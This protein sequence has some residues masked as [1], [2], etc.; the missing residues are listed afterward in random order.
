MSENI[1]LY[2]FQGLAS[3]LVV[4]IHIPFPGVVGTVVTAWARISVPLFFMI[5][6]YSLYNHLGTSNFRKKIIQR[7]KRN[8]AITAFGLIIYF[9]VDVGKCILKKESVW[10]FLGPVLSWENLVK[11]FLLGVIPPGTGGVLWFMIALVY[12]YTLLLFLEPLLKKE[13]ITIWGSVAFICMVLLGLIK[14]TTTALNAHIS[15]FYLG[16]NWIYGNW[17]AI[18]LPAFLIGMSLC[19]VIEE[20]TWS[21][22]RCQ[23]ILAIMT[24]CITATS[25]ESLVLKRNL[26][27]YLSYTIFTLI[28]DVCIFILAQKD[29]FCPQNPI[30]KLGKKYSRDLYLWHPLVMSAVSITV[31]RLRLGDNI[32]VMYLQP[33]I[34]LEMS[35]LFSVL[36][37]KV[38]R[39]CKW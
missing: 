6:G 14:I 30:V 7:I 5:S 18:G 29:Y 1:T 11:F 9:F 27:M 25:I 19:K 10:T 35:L 17:I 15:S 21:K 32:I 38:E 16:S 12:I 20:N 39:V 33:V 31:T 13:K 34:V 22:F 8:G 2:F 36:L 4:F 28:V 3:L 24:I 37:N 23:Y 26:D